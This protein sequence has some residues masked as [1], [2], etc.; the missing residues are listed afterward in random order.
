MLNLPEL[1]PGCGYIKLF[2]TPI[3]EKE[4]NDFI[5]EGLYRVLQYGRKTRFSCSECIMSK[6]KFTAKEQG[7]K[8]VW[9][10]RKIEEKTKVWGVYFA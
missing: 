2:M 7:G 1:F 9:V 5:Q 8:W 3:K 10:V 4:E 6:W